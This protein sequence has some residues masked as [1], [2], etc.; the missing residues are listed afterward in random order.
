VDLGLAIKQASPFR[1]THVI[2]LSSC[3]ETMYLPTRAACAGGSNEVTNSA[4]MPGSGEILVE[5]AVRLLREVANE[6]VR[7][8]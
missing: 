4:L 6:N 3:V 1:T 8:K 2:E 7:K 5:A